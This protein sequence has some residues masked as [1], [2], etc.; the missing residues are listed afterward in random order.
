[1]PTIVP[2]FATQLGLN[3][4][5]T[6]PVDT[7]LDFVRLN[8]GA[9]ENLIDGNAMRGTRSRSLE[10]VRI[11]TRAVGG[12]IVFWPTPVE[13]AYLLPWIMGAGPTGG[14]QTKTYSLASVLP[15]KSLSIDRVQFVQNSLGVVV[16]RATFRGRR[17]QPLEVE[18]DLMGIDE[19]LGNPGTFPSLTADTTSKIFVFHDA[20]VSINSTTYQLRDL[21]LVIDNRVDGERYLNSQTRTALYSMDRQVSF[22]TNI[23]WGDASGLYQLAGTDGFS[24]STTWTFG[25][26]AL[27]FTMPK[28]FWMRKPIEIPGREELYYPMQG[29]G[30]ATAADNELSCTLD[31]TPGS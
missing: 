9:D 29:M 15:T 19:A 5:G 14:G 26:C 16:N 1:M 18:L 25:N 30:L 17:G 8:Y 28:A 13:L 4:A 20:A 6:I 3:S 31:S 7:K 23:P 27:N 11:G 24:F 2:G 12:T 10:R 21:D 22:L